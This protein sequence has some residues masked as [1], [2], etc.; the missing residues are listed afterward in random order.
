MRAHWSRGLGSRTHGAP[1]YGTGGYD[2]VHPGYE[3]A[4]TATVPERG[5]LNTILRV[6]VKIVTEIFAD[7]PCCWTRICTVRLPTNGECGA[8]RC[9]KPWSVTS[10]WQTAPWDASPHLVPA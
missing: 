8:L 6:N 9:A 5:P 3:Q 7:P 2:G 1:V 10:A 4:P